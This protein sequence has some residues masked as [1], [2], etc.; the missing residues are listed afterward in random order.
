MLL[1]SDGKAKEIRHL[2]SLTSVQW[3]KVIILSIDLYS[4]L[5]CA[6]PMIILGCLLSRRLNFCA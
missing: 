4:H 6:I 2:R 5:I 1:F 3:Y